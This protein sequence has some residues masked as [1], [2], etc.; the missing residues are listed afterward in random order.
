MSEVFS[1][2]SIILREVDLENISST[3]PWNLSGVS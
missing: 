2:L 3:I 1:Y